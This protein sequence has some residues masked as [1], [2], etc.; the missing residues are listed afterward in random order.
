MKKKEVK[1]EPGLGSIP[2]IKTTYWYVRSN[3]MTMDFVLVETE[4]V[5]SFSDL[6][7][8]TKGNVYLDKNEAISVQNMLND[9]LYKLR[10]KCAD[11]KQKE[12]LAAEL[13]QK[14]LEAAE[15]KRIRDLEKKKLDKE[16]KKKAILKAE[17]DKKKKKSPHPDIIV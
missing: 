4:W 5:G 9:R 1:V 14:K 8:L 11:E 15:R 7:R 6:F 13:A 17:F 3:M 16:A 2:E 10:D 12:R